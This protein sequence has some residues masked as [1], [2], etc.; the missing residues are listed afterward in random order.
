MKDS[1]PRRTYQIVPVY[2]GIKVA[3]SPLCTNHAIQ[4]PC[5]DNCVVFKPLTFMSSLVVILEFYI[6]TFRSKEELMCGT[7]S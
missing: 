6:V 2:S 5:K 4:C 1:M 3:F 7:G